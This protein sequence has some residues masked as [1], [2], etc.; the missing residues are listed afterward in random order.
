MIKGGWMRALVVGVLATGCSHT[1]NV[2]R[3]DVAGHS[4]GDVSARSQL[5]NLEADRRQAASATKS[6]PYHQ[7]P[8]PE[9]SLVKRNPEIKRTSLLPVPDREEYGIDGEIG[10]PAPPTRLPQAPEASGAPPE[11][12]ENPTVKA[13]RCYLENCPEEAE[14]TL[15]E[16]PPQYRE[17][18]AC[19]L[20]LVAHL[21][22]SEVTPNDP[23][24]DGLLEQL[25]ELLVA[26]EPEERK[27]LD[28]TT[29]CFCRRIETFGVY[30]PLPADYSFRAGELVHV[31]V[32][33]KNFTSLEEK[34]T[35]G[36]RYF[37]TRLTGR[38]EISDETGQVVW[39][40][41]F[42]RERPDLSRTTRHDYF[43]HYQFCLPDLPTGT[44][45]LWI[46]VTD[47]PTSSVVEKALRFRIVNE[48]SAAAPIR[49]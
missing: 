3:F 42:Q 49:R 17:L 26:P 13:L 28:I 19:L 9:I 31:Y 36:E 2:G 40:Q 11:K 23:Q 48:T 45:S 47:E 21:T 7:L 35:E 43:D 4:P 8:A 44:Y 29:M 18:L 38:A 41:D 22:T 5:A 10:P 14:A 37:T 12:P 30:E 15:A 1:A 27:E 32:E 25:K 20:P 46:R 24:K 33:V 6:S 39:T 34:T 16:F